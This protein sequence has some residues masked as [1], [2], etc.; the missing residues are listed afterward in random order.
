MTR[1]ASI[2]RS[3]QAIGI[4]P[5]LTTAI[6]Y[7]GHPAVRSRGTVGGTVA[8]ADPAAEI[9][10]VLLALGGEVVARGPAGERTIAA[11]DFFVSYFTTALDETELVTQ[12]RIP[13]PAAGLRFGFSEVARKP[14][15][16]ALAGVALA[17]VVDEAG[18]CSSA[19]IALFG[20]ADRPVRAL[21]AEEALAGRKLADEAVRGDAAKL[22]CDG[23]EP[24]EDGHATREY[25]RSVTGVLVR[26]ALE[27]AATE[28]GGDHEH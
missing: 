17:A 18:L 13:R 23:M 19:R 10:A 24:R 20:V 9:P 27:Q 28:A 14:S 4:A 1:Q 15:D 16:F 8:H 22:A 3:A 11:D 5:L 25:R 6:G 21:R 12:I 2:A 7:V 26:R